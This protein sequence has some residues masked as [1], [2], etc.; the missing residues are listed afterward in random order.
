MSE[1]IVKWGIVEIM[2]HRVVAGQIEGDPPYSSG[3]LVKIP[4]PDGTFMEEFYGA[5]AIFGVRVVPEALARKAAGESWHVSQMTRYMLP[6]SDQEEREAAQKPPRPTSRVPIY[7]QIDERLADGEYDEI[8]AGQGAAYW[9]DQIE[10]KLNLVTEHDD[11][12]PRTYRRRLIDLAAETIAAI[13]SHDRNESE[14]DELEVE[15]LEPPDG[16][17]DPV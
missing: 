9:E 10:S 4:L 12:D 2:G 1:K 11:A 8:V 5:A 13:E 3:V 16:E 7:E 15:D 14:D 6:A 17:D